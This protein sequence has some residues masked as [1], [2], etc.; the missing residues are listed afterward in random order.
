M[1]QNQEE[2]WN[3][4]AM[5]LAL[6]GSIG[7][8]PA[9]TNQATSDR[10]CPLLGDIL[11]ALVEQF[12]KYVSLPTEVLYLIALWI[13]QTYCFERF[14]YVGYLNIRS[15]LPRC[16]KTRLLELLATFAFGN[17]SVMTLPT[18][19]VIFDGGSRY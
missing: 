13:A 12:R 19:A 3:P 1:R 8:P 7:V 17:P 9:N 15:P 5:R 11:D 14:E 2:N 6:R 4:L 16:G 18:P 10:R